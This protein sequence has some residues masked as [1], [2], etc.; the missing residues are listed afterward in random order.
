LSFWSFIGLASKKDFDEV[1]Q[2]LGD[3]T[4]ILEGLV[5]HNN[6]INNSIG[7]VEERINNTF[8]ETI[9]KMNDSVTATCES[10]I[11]YAATIIDMM[12]NISENSSNELISTNKEL[13]GKI[14]TINESLKK[15]VISVNN[16]LD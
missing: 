2:K 16:M 6:L 15:V 8:K 9:S 3:M 14:D 1:S 5:Q 13:N 12:K 10:N 11:K 7:L 4:V